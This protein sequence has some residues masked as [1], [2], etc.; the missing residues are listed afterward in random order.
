M[1]LTDRPS[2]NVR[3]VLLEDTFATKSRQEAPVWHCGDEIRGHLEVMTRGN[4]EFEITV[5]FEGLFDIRIPITTEV[6]KP[7]SRL[8][9]DMDRARI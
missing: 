1:D 6:T 8:R 3:I 9:P 4:F 7:T 2:V 5:S